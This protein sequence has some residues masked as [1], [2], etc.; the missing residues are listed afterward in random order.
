MLLVER[1]WIRGTSGAGK[2]T[3][4]IRVAQRL[5]IEAVDLDDLNWLPGWVERSHDEF[6]DLVREV[7]DRPRWVLAGNYGKVSPLVGP[8]VDTIVWLDYSLPV[9]FGRILR[10]TVR[11]CVT[12]EACCNGNREDLW[13][14]FLMRDSVVWW[15]LTTHARRRR[16]CEAFMAE[17]PPEG[18]VRLRHQTPGETRAWL[19]ALPRA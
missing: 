7:V 18:Q 19:R 6:L 1:I 8:I 9:T 15:S 13:R 10:R 5:G 4:G 11:R 12:G 2:T 14:S 3:L 17:T 16:E